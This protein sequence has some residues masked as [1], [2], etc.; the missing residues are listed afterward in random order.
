MRATDLLMEEHLLIERGLRTLLALAE[1]GKP[2]PEITAVLSFLSEFADG[3]HHAKEE[4]ILFPALEEAGFPAD[5]GPVAVMLHEHDMGRGFI[6][7]MRQNAALDTDEARRAFREAA[8]GYADLL[9][10]HISKENNV[11]FRMADNAIQGPDRRRVEEDF[12]TY[13]NGAQAVRSRH[14]TELEK[15]ASS[16]GT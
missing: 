12:D 8:K 9:S 4:K 2:G 16:V 5:S 1:R 11:L 7:Q 14:Q 13:E 6:A 15:L 3:H 10:Q